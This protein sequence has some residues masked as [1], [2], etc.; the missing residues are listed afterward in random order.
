MISVQNEGSSK[1]GH[2][3]AWNPSHQLALEDALA[4]THHSCTD[5]CWISL[6]RKGEIKL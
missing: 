5:S 3:T 2:G 6:Q 1:M 4:G